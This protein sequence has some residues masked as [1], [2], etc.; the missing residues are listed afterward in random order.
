[1]A[2]PLDTSLFKTI[3]ANT[4][5]ISIDLVVQDSQNRILLGKRLNRPA[6]NYWF[7]PGGRVRKDETLADAFT[8]L[9]KEELGLATSI[10]NAAFIGP[11]EHF[12]PDNFSEEEFS[13]HYVVLGYKLVIETPLVQLPKD[14]H[15]QYCW[16]A[17]DDLL[18]ADDVHLHTKLYF[19]DRK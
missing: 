1:M 5:L 11:F 4:P 7:V 17:V 9:A 18:S 12:Y 2:R 15:S 16:R 3:V 10:Q 8:R 14:Q 19:Q 13:T 6:K